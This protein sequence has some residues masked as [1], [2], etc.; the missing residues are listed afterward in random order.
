MRMLTAALALTLG[1]GANAA[2]DASFDMRVSEAR[3]HMRAAC[4][5]V[6]SLAKPDAAGNPALVETAGAEVGNA[7]TL[8][9]AIV[10]DYAAVTPAGYAGDPGWKQRL[11]DIRLDLERMQRETAAHEWRLA[12]LSCAHAC[13]WITMMHEANGVTLA[14]DTMAALRKRVGILK[15]LVA[16]GQAERGRPL[17]KEVLAARDAVLLSP[18]PEGPTRDAFLAA[19]PELS[20]AVDALAEAARSGADLTAPA[21][22]LAAIVERVYELAI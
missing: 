7:V 9:S 12:F 19:L 16:V 17:V 13:N 10:R 21:S 11:E 6:Q 5:A 20:R 15:G 1:V 22:S 2:D 3:R 18:P 8:W 4:Q 14:I